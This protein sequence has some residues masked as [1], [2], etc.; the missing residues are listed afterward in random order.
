MFKL[1]I[2]KD[3]PTIVRI[4]Q[5][6]EIGIAASFLVSGH[7]PVDTMK[8][9]TSNE[10]GKLFNAIPV[11]ID[12]NLVEGS[13]A[14]V[15][16][17]KYKTEIVVKHNIKTEDKDVPKDEQPRREDSI[18]SDTQSNRYIMCSDKKGSEAVHHA[19]DGGQDQTTDE[20]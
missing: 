14:F 13:A 9:M 8:K 19:D 7:E 4:V 2:D 6:Y 17:G 16:E 11:K 18:A 1:E 15:N 5:T 10:I 3:D 20:R 12:E